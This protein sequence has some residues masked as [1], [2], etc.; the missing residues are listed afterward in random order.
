[1]IDFAGKF[2]VGL[3]YGDFLAAYG[4]DEHRRMWQ[5]VHDRVVLTDAHHE[6]LAGFK[7][8]MKVLCMAGAWC[9]DCVQQCPIF[10]H[11]AAASSRIQLR[12]ADRDA[13]EELKNELTVCGGARVPAVVFLSEDGQHVGRYGDGTISY[14][15]QKA[16]SQLG[17]RPPGVAAPE[18][19]LLAAV[20]Q[21]WLNEFERI[22][23]I[24]RTSPRLRQ[25]HGD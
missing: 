2:V 11:F 17:S 12:F 8:E 18:G 25:K 1:M 20:V 21:D 7:R 22:Q 6:L 14:Y 10:D 13:D 24:L 23:L 16:A 4:A 19:D 15:R 9:G 3:S 5:G